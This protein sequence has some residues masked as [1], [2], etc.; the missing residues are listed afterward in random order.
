MHINTYF[1]T[2]V[3]FLFKKFLTDSL[4]LISEWCCLPGQLLHSNFLN[5][6]TVT[7]PCRH[8]N[9]ICFFCEETNI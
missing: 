5:N 6:D 3:Y 1:P 2:Y 7:I 9:Q 4:D 8:A